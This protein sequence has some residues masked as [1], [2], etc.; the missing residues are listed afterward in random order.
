[1]KSS[2]FD[3]G[4]AHGALRIWHWMPAWSATHD[5]AVPPLHVNRMPE[6]WS[7]ETNLIDCDAQGVPGEWSCDRSSGDGGD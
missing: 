7:H 1:M 4:L 5:D 2:G 3:G 6:L